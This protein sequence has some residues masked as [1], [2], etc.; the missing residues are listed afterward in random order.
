MKQ[1]TEIKEST[2]KDIIVENLMI[3]NGVYLLVSH[4][5]VGKSMFAQQL[6]F[7]LTTGEVP[8]MSYILPQR[9][10]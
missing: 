8:L 9:E 3:S 6:A 4:P 2:K 7:S 1:L 5:K 10:I